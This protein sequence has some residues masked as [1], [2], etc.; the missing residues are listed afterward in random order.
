MPSSNQVITAG[1]VLTVAV[2]FAQTVA[3]LIDFRFYDLRLRLLD[4]DHHRSLFGALSILAEALAAAAIA[5]RAVSGRRLAWLLVTVVVGLLTVPRALMGYV[6]A[7]Q[8]YDVP[9][10]AAPLGLVF[11]MLCALTFRDARSV[12]FVV[13]GSLL[14]LG[15]SF[16]L[17]AVG[18]QAD[19][20]GSSP[21]L[22]THTWAYQVTG[23]LKHGAELAGWILLATAMVG[24]AATPTENGGRAS[25]GHDQDLEPASRRTA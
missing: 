9:V 12:R 18:P 1:L 7:F 4:S 17:H 15:C 8:Q 13:W 19:A 22:S 20:G 14:L 25:E 16:A 24:A 2:V 21:S 11:V 23:I 5:L 6:V 3:Q 10:L